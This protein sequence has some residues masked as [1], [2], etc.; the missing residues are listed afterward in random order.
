LY[1]AKPY[2]IL[3]IIYAPAFFK[4]FLRENRGVDEQR[5]LVQVYASGRSIVADRGGSDA[6]SPYLKPENRH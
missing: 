5:P 1:L 3:I 4:S 6:G 2:T